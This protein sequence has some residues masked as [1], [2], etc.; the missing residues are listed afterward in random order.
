MTASAFLKLSAFGSRGGLDRVERVSSCRFDVSAATWD[1]A[2]DK[3]DE[4]ERH[5]QRR[6][7]QCEAMFNG[8]IY[9]MHAGSREGECFAGTFLRT[10]FKSYLYWRET[11]FPE[12]GVID[13]F[14]SSLIRSAEGHV[15]LG[16]QRTGNVNAGIAYLPGGFIDPRDVTDDGAIDIDGSILR[17]LSEETGLNHG[18]FEL[19]P[20]LLR[21]FRAVHRR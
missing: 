4:I 7:A 19:T 13:G 17:E 10:D 20:G 12:A 8:A 6:S 15:V 11:G 1:Y 21:F 5:W 3:A 18:Q 16:R 9:L 14:G 2:R